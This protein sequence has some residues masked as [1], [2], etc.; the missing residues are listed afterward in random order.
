M[1][2]GLCPHVSG[3]SGAK[4]GVPILGG[5]LGL[6]DSGP[7]QGAPRNPAAEG[8]ALRTPR[9]DHQRE[10]GRRVHL[11]PTLWLV[12]HLPARAWRFIINCYL[13]LP[14]D[15]DMPS[16]VLKVLETFCPLPPSGE[17]MSFILFLKVV[18][19]NLWF[20]FL[21]SPC[22][23]SDPQTLPWEDSPAFPWVPVRKD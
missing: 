19:F 3:G 9:A 18:F 16:K 20:L 17:G 21:Q 10:E 4:P 7:G 1:G 14:P 13:M 11:I 8:A 5:P 23:T 15:P 2:C 6:V 12:L 22:R